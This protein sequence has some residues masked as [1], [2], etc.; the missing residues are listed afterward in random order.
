MTGVVRFLSILGIAVHGFLFVASL[1]ASGMSDSGSERGSAL[2]FFFMPFVY[3]TYCFITS[4][5]SFK[6]P[7]LVPS[8][9]L[10]HLIIIPFYF[11]AVRDGIG[12]IV[13]VPLTL[14]P[15]WF[16]MCFQRKEQ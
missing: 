3:F 8:G 9:I 13:I 1:G 16:R 12:V 5:R 7:L 11:R 10:A 6:G 2:I 14:A 4:F 15:C